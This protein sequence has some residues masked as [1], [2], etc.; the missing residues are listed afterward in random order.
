MANNNGGLA[1]ALA[2]SMAAQENRELQQALG[3]SAEHGRGDV[4]TGALD[5]LTTGNG[6][7]PL[8]RQAR[9]VLL[10][11]YALDDI[12]NFYAR[13][14][15]TGG[16]LNADR[17]AAITQLS[18]ALQV[19]L[20]V[21]MDVA[22]AQA[23]IDEA[24]AQMAGDESQSF[25]ME[26][27]VYPQLLEVVMDMDERGIGNN[28][29]AAVPPP[30]AVPVFAPGGAGAA[31]ANGNIGPMI[32]VGNLAAAAAASGKKALT[33]PPARFAR[34]QT[35]RYR[36]GAARNQ[37]LANFLGAGKRIIRTRQRP[38]G[39]WEYTIE[40]RMAPIVE[41]NLL[42]VAGGGKRRTNRKKRRASKT[43]RN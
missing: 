11:V 21:V 34:G 22:S 2:A 8:S 28:V 24:D 16:N 41:S 40:G 1:E 35:V 7:G 27:S 31:A 38:D 20:P 4:F 32:N 15:A 10:R 9:Q 12:L 39:V 42:H 37:S 3:A 29:P 43:R 25:F 26:G 5:V 13:R 6:G 18:G 36:N 23:A 33:G 17:R 19:H 30:M 14:R